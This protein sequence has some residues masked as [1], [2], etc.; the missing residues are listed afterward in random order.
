MTASL[1]DARIV[2][3]AGSKLLADAVA[4][5]KQL[6][7]DGKNIDDHQVVTERVAYAA[8]EAVAAHETLNEV[9]AWSADGNLTPM[10]EKTD[11][12]PRSASSSRTLRDRLSL[13][14]DDLGIGDAALESDLHRR[15]AH[16]APPH[17]PAEALLREIG[18]ERRRDGRAQRLAVLDEMHEQVRDQV[19]EFGAERGHAPRG[20]H[21]SHRRD[22]P[23]RVH[24]RT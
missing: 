20:A 11:A 10:R 17:L 4:A 2:L 9:D 23:R 14:V 16:G 7:A 1:D 19:R 5:A 24:R 21:P 12:S 6:T 22:D 13:A 8:T 18:A 3:D 15:G